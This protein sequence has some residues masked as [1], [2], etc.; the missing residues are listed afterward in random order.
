MKRKRI[1]PEFVELIPEAVKEGVLYISFR[2]ATATHKCPCGCG[3]IVVTPIRPTDWTLAWDGDTVSLNPSVGNWSLP[4]QSHY[5][6]TRNRII[7]AG[8]WNT[9]QIGASRAFDKLAKSRYY[10]RNQEW[11]E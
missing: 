3:E 5:W 8:K 10:G 1:K 2:Y 6:I 9:L 11:K 4:C 7:W